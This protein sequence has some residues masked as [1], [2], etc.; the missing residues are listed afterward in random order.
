M[1]RF[2]AAVAVFLCGSFEAQ[3]VSIAEGR[4][5]VTHLIVQYCGGGGFV[6]GVV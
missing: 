2:Y 1:Y 4:A 6:L 5:V 3:E